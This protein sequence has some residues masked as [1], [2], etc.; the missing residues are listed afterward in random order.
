MGRQHGAV[1]REPQPQSF[2]QA[3]LGVG[4]KHTR[5]GTAGRTGK[6]FHYGNNFIR[7]GCIRTHHHGIYQVQTLAVRHAP[8]F[9][10]ASGYKNSRYIQPHGG[11]KHPRSDLVTVGYADHSIDLVGI[12]HV[13][14]T[15]GYDFS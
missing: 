6:L 10:G 15:V 3:V 9:H 5:A 1:S 2:H 4:R 11:H 14:N 8:G 7:H 13:F 12:A